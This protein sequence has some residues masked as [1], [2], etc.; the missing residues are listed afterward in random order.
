MAVG[1]LRKSGLGREDL[2]RD[3]ATFFLSIEV[4]LRDPHVCKVVL[5]QGRFASSLALSRGGCPVRGAH[6]AFGFR[7]PS[8]GLGGGLQHGAHHGGLGTDEETHAVA[9]KKPWKSGQREG[10]AFAPCWRL[11]PVFTSPSGREYE[12]SRIDLLSG[13]STKA[14]SDAMGSSGWGTASILVRNRR[15]KPRRMRSPKICLSRSR[16]AASHSVGSAKLRRAPLWPISSFSRRATIVG[17]PARGRTTAGCFSPE[18]SLGKLQ[19]L[20]LDPS[21][22]IKAPAFASVAVSL[23][24]TQPRNM[25]R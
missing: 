8:A 22:T 5:R 24:H 16:W 11:F 21:L 19:T 15:H 4:R 1:Q 25:V 13:R 23:V 20:N 18:G 10:K 6:N 14:S 12:P 2:K 3:G 7:F 9:C 17:R